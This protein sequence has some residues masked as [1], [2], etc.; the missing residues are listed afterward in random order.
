MVP[1]VVSRIYVYHL[2][3]LSVYLLTCYL[4]LRMILIN[5][6]MY[7]GNPPIALHG[8]PACSRQI[9]LQNNPQD[10]L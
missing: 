4:L 7:V 2:T 1:L 3:N 5:D 9:A 6:E 10:N 8:T